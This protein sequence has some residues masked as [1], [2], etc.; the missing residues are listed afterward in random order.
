MKIKLTSALLLLITIISCKSTT[1]NQGESTTNYEVIPLPEMITTPQADA[2]KPFVLTADT[3]ITYPEGDASLQ[4]Y[5]GFLQE[6]IK[7]QA[8]IEVNIAPNQNNETN[9]IALLQNYQNNNKEAYQVVVNAKNITVNG[10][11]KA[12]TFYG[13][14]LLRKSIPVQK[15]GKVI[16]PA[17]EI[18]DKPYFA[19]RG[20][21]LDSARHFFNA[22]SVRIYIDMLALH[23]INKF[24]WHLTDDQ[25]WRFESKKYPELTVVGS[26]RS[27][28]MVN[29]QWDTFDGKPHGGF[30]TQQE[31]KDIV[32]YA[33]D[34]N[35][36]VIPEIDLP[37]HMVA[38][39]AT[40]P[41][42][43][44]TGGPYKVRET[45]GIAEDVLCA[46]NPETYDFI[47][48]ILEEVTEVFPSEYI[49]IGGDECPKDSWKKC[50][51]CQ[52]KIKELGIKGDAK[53]TAE[54]YLQSH[55]ITFAEDVL[56]KK[57]RKIIGWDEILEGGLAPNATV[58]SW[59]GIG[60]AIE[61]AKSNHDAIMTPVSYCYF[62]YYQTDKTDK[63][64]LAIGGYVPVERVYSFNPYPD[65]LNKEQQK[66]ILG[67]QANVWT[68]YIK[69]FKHVQY[70]VLPRFAALAEVQWEDPAKPKDYNQFLQ[71]LMRL[72]P[73]YQLEGYNYAKH[74]FDLRAEVKPEVGDIQVTL[75]CL[76]DTPIYYTTD[77]SEP[78][79]SSN[80]YKEPLKLTQDTHLK[81]KV[82]GQETES[83]FEQQFLFNKAT[84]RPIE[85]LS[86][87][88]QNYTFGGAITLVDGRKGGT[89]SRSGEWLGFSEAPCEVVITLKENT[90]VKEVRFNA[91]IE[92]GD[93]I[94][95][96][97]SFE[98]WGSKDGKSYN[99]LAKENYALPNK[100]LKEIKT[101]SLSFPEKEVT[102]LKVKI[103]GV[104]K[105]PA[106]HQG[107]AGKPGFLFI[108]EIQ[109]L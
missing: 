29:K 42:L 17:K 106:F 87:P 96:P 76:Q 78:T 72:L 77:G 66:H 28:T 109:V 97:T 35:I 83:S 73:I 80:V 30:Y 92:T 63:E 19:Y 44:C 7:K 22:D 95:P 36:T 39:L 38:A 61:A 65:A 2:D 101:Y 49:H 58:M 104:N 85:F 27:Q 5:A 82:F 52:A 90:P 60:G 62:D 41:Q 50:P 86:K 33:A 57:G 34:R 75:S 102:Y 23:N 68:E 94:Y 15:V 69:T 13:V 37:G 81:A 16:F 26:T 11:S 51:K 71:R 107:A 3:K 55:I 10:A 1:N 18:T 12:G 84:V 64:P 99:L 14:Q 105:I 47:K 88:S 59:R 43:G 6:Y 25:G 40:Y 9:T 32:K 21:H 20:A 53:H 79:K 74:I 45:W 108:D 89:N 24:H 70:M 67:V 48:N 8:G 4:Q 98:V 103:N 31:M 100:A 46:G 91:F 56:A 54:E 93:W